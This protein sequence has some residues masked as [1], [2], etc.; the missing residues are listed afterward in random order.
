V[1]IQEFFASPTTITQGEEVTLTWVTTGNPD[2]FVMI[3]DEFSGETVDFTGL[4]LSFGSVTIRPEVTVRP[5]LQASKGDLTATAFL[6]EAITVIPPDP[7]P[8]PEPPVIEFFIADQNVIS[9]GER[10]AFFWRVSGDITQLEL[11][12]FSNGAV[13]DVTGTTSFLTPPFVDPGTYTFNLLATGEDGTLARSTLTITVNIAENLPVVI[14]EIVQEPA[15]QID[16]QDEGSFRFTITDPERRDS[17]WRVRKIA[18]DFASF[19]PREGIIPRGQGQDS[20]AFQDGEENDNGFLT[21][22]LSAFDDDIFG[23]SNGSTRAV[24]LI[25]FLT[26]GVVSD[27]AP[28]I[29][30]FTFEPSGP[31]TAPGTTG[32]L[33][34]NFSDPDTLR[35]RWSVAIVSGDFG[36]TLSQ[37]SGETDTGAGTIQVSYVDDPDTPQDPVVFLVRVEELGI[38]NPQFT[39]ATLR[40]D[41]SGNVEPPASGDPISFPFTGMF[42]N[43]DGDLNPNEEMANFTVF[44]NGDLVDPRFFRNADLS[45][46]VP[47]VSYVVDLA[48]NTNDP[49]IINEVNFA[50]NFQVPGNSA[51]NT[52]NMTLIGYY[53]TSGVQGAPSATPIE[54]GVVRYRLTF[55]AEDFRPNDMAAY[56]LP[57]AGVMDYSVTVEAVDINNDVG[58]VIKAISVVVPDP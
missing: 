47:A 40:V 48:S 38:S 53:A 51:G 46:E 14:S 24:E 4:D 16:N 49:S 29:N 9:S 54:G 37:V 1:V 25:T 20:V 39:V 55:T 35:L 8:G 5:I 41:K 7:P 50:R 11:F 34:F 2:Q 22:E 23:F 52:G 10:V 45:G 32:S 56:N 12:P 21:F 27:T 36:G 26:N 30:S 33:L 44:F 6:R 28:V 57:A 42:G 13:V 17:S 3:P 43:F 31:E 58:S 15:T 19:F 18:G